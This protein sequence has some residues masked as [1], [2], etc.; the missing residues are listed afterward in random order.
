MTDP[1]R[2]RRI[3]EVCDAALDR[4]ARER[5]AFVAAACGRRRR[6][7]TGGRGAAGARADRRRGFSRRRSAKSRRTSWLMSTAASLVG[8]ADRFVQDSVSP[9]RGRDGRGVSRPRYETGPRRRHQGRGRRLPF[10]P[11]AARALRTRG[12]GAGDAEPSAHRRD[13]WIGGGRRRPRPR[14]RARRRRDARRASG[15][16]SVA[17]SGGTHGRAPDRGRA[18]SRAR[19]GH[20]PPRSE[21]GEHQDHA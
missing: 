4:D 7:A 16:G 13:L 18:R 11:G 21:T 19:E 20:H 5:A 8:P 3:E 1:E 17:D 14:A 9:R 10:R 6:A 15:G 2:R 12:A